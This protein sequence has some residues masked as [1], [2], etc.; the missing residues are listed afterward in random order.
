MWTAGN[1]PFWAVLSLLCLLAGTGIYALLRPLPW[2]PWQGA[3]I[4]VPAWLVFGLPDGLWTAAFAASLLSMGP[5]RASARVCW[6]PAACL[7]MLEALQATRHWPGTADAADLLWGLGGS[8][9]VIGI[10]YLVLSWK[11]E[12]EKALICS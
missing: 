9:F 5:D 11:K 2:M 3:D 8:A 10:H 1:R 4:T 7:M 6:W 12:P